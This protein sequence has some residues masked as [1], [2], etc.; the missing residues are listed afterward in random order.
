M[1]TLADEEL[2]IFKAFKNWLYARKLSSLSVG[3]LSRLW[4][5]GDR[6]EIPLL[7][8]ECINQLLLSMQSDR[9]VPT[10]LVPYIYKN[11]TA[12]SPL[13]RVIV[14]VTAG[15]FNTTTVL[16][17]KGPTSS[18]S[19]EPMRDLAIA[20]IVRPTVESWSALV[21]RSCDWHIHEEGVRCK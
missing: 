21:G 17:P 10:G 18:W 1:I 13:R 16:E 5:L 20:L 19:E 14:E 4:C 2:E 12:G 7:Q 6:R 9:S 8:N 3:V 15:L 11:T